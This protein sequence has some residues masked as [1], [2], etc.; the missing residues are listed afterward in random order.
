P[1]GPAPLP[2]V[3]NL[4]Q[5]SPIAP[6]NTYHQWAK[7]YGDIISINIMG[8]HVIVLNSVRS[9]SDLLQKRSRLY[10]DRPEL[11]AATLLGWDYNLAFMQYSD[12]RWKRQ[13][14]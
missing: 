3:G 9:A 13:R 7:V 6:W 1:P 4:F 10:S 14:K 8:K 2:F 11:A 5:L 12:P